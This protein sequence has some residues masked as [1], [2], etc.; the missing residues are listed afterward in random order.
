MKRLLKQLIDWV[1]KFVREKLH[2]GN[3][4][5][6]YY[7]IIFV[8]LI[9]F[10]IALNGFVELTD[11]LAENQLEGFDSTVTD[12]VISSRSNFLTGYFIFMT[13]MGDRIGYTIVSF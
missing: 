4:E 6:P 1:R 9:L 2:S 7:I 11:E 12:F 5:L 10:A 3:V 8:A 13:N